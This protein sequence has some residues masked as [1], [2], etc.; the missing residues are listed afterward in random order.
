MI[1]LA[2][3]F[4]KC[5]LGVGKS[6]IGIF[7]HLLMLALYLLPI[8]PILDYDLMI[9]IQ[10]VLSAFTGSSLLSRIQ[11]KKTLLKALN[12]IFLSWGKK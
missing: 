5:R 4:L 9:K 6:E 12:S 7:L 11:D 1:A 3:G 8:L 2:L 10:V